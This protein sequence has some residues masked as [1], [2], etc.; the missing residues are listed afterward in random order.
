[1]IA[2]FWHF[3]YVFYQEEPVY[4]SALLLFSSSDPALSRFCKYFTFSRCI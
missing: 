4:I 1:M 2:Y 3:S